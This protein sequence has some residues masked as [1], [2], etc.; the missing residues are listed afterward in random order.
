M[1]DRHDVADDFRAGEHLGFRGNDADG[2]QPLRRSA[3][4]TVLHDH[5][6]AQDESSAMCIDVHGSPRGS[7]TA[8]SGPTRLEAF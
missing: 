6:D 3:K 4:F 2:R 1:C 5:Q 8:K 7:I